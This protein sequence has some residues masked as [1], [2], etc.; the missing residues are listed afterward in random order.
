MAE[1]G[2]TFPSSHITMALVVS[3]LALRYEKKLGYILIVITFGI[4]VATVYL[5][6]H[7]A[8]DPFFGLMLGGIF[9]PIGIKWIKS[10]GEDPLSS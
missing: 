10:R 5:G 7:H 4:A 3:L 6:Y 1:G 9:Y 2:G 8:I